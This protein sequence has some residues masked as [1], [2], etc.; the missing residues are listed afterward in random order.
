MDFAKGLIDA[1]YK[2][3]WDVV[4]PENND[5]EP[6]ATP[7]STATNAKAPTSKMRARPAMTRKQTGVGESSRA[8]FDRDEFSKANSRPKLV[9]Y[10][11]D[12]NKVLQERI[13]RAER[14]RKKVITPEHVDPL[15]VAIISDGSMEADT[16][17]EQDELANQ[18]RLKEQA[19]FEREITER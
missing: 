12:K 2:T 6:S 10:K 15:S 4:E 11:A 8:E 3:S 9:N 19:E 1:V 7:K 14:R 18:M 5:V 13:D 17:K 16:I